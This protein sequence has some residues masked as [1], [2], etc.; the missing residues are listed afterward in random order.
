MPQ[1]E[2]TLRILMKTVSE[3]RQSQ[4]YPGF[5]ILAWDDEKVQ[6]LDSGDSY[7]MT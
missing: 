7:T 6:E 1:Y 2:Q 5:G 3:I 4:K